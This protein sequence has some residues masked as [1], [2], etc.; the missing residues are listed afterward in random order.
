MTQGPEPLESIRSMISLLQDDPARM[1]KAARS[2]C[3]TPRSH[4]ETVPARCRATQPASLPGVHRLPQ[5]LDRFAIGDS[6]AGELVR[7]GEIEVT[8]SRP[9]EV[10]RATRI[11]DL[12]RNRALKLCPATVRIAGRFFRCRPGSPQREHLRFTLFIRH[13]GTQ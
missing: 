1:A 12:R 13:L 2:I 5:E 10:H 4:R 8:E 3:E 7:D 11:A 9:V 6:C